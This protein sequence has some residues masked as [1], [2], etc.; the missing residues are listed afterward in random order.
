MDHGHVVTDSRFGDWAGGRGIRS[1]KSVG[2]GISRGPE[3][4]GVQNIER[5]GKT[6]HNTA[7]VFAGRSRMHFWR[8][9]GVE[10]E[11]Y[12][13]VGT[14]RTN[15]DEGKPAMFQPSTAECVLAD[16]IKEF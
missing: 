2:G 3:N 13:Y 4:E 9:G 15:C 10:R 1:R 7:Q 6:I 11:M 14:P 5:S 8:R 12:A 16:V